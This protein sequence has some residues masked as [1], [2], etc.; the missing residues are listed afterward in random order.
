MGGYKMKTRVEEITIWIGEDGNKV[1][2]RRKKKSES[3]EKMNMEE[4]REVVCDDTINFT[5]FWEWLLEKA[6]SF[7]S[8]DAFL[9]DWLQEKFEEWNKK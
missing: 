3:M 7:S 2:F 5:L 1:A 4:L 6:Y 9:D 8:D